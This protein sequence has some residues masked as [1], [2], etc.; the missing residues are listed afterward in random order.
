MF[1]MEIK[2]IVQIAKQIEQTGR[3]DLTLDRQASLALVDLINIIKGSIGIHSLELDI[4]VCNE[5]S[6]FWKEFRKHEGKEHICDISIEKLR[7]RHKNVLDLAN[8]R[9]KNGDKYDS[10]GIG[11]LIAGKFYKDVWASRS[12]SG[13][14]AELMGNVDDDAYLDYYCGSSNYFTLMNYASQSELVKAFEAAVKL[15][16]YDPNSQNLQ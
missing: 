11:I 8:Q 6:L 10:E 13:H 12:C 16:G 1:N 4:R 9:D 15:D 14:L 2:D 7:A 5:S 3:P